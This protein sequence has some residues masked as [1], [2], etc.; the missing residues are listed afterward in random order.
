MGEKYRRGI[1]ALNKM[2]S[3]FSM[4]FVPGGGGLR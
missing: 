4:N 2:D 3:M 1:Q